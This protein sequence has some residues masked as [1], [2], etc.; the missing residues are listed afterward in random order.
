M[1]RKRRE[2]CE[3]VSCDTPSEVSIYDKSVSSW[4]YRN[5][6]FVCINSKSFVEIDAKPKKLSS[7]FITKLCKNYP[8]KN[9]EYTETHPSM[10][11]E[12]CLPIT[13]DK[14]VLG[15]LNLE[16]SK[17]NIYCQKNI[18][19]IREDIAR[20]IKIPARRIINIRQNKFM[21]SMINAISKESYEERFAEAKDFLKEFIGYSVFIVAIKNKTNLELEEYDFNENITDAKANE[22][23]INH[24]INAQSAIKDFVENNED[25]FLYIEN[26]EEY[27]GIVSKGDNGKAQFLAKLSSYNGTNG[28]IS[29]QFE[30]K[31]PLNEDKMALLKGFVKWFNRDINEN[32]ANKALRDRERYFREK[33]SMDWYFRNLSHIIGGSVANITSNLEVMEDLLEDKKALL[34]KIESSQEYLQAIANF[35]KRFISSNEY[36]F[37]SIEGAYEAVK[38]DLSLRIGSKKIS[39]SLETVAISA[40]HSS[41]IYMILFHPILNALEEDSIS[42][43]EISAKIEKEA[44]IIIISD[45]GDG[46]NLLKVRAVVL[47]FIILKNL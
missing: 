4:V 27:K 15:V 10:R 7:S 5:N 6:H 11:S 47:D 3:G 46:F 21:R 39:K 2:Y 33:S 34:E 20:F 35:P 18:K 28:V 1:R 26:M 37:D 9:I 41:I 38:N 13:V 42:E 29:F 22:D 40:S 25:E 16:T 31:N 14:Q 24:C 32:I 44:Y 30:V 12:I 43:I 36:S 8:D 17:E 19:K 23:V 45:N